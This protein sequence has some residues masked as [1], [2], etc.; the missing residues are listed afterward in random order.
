MEKNSKIFVAG[1][2]GLVGSAIVRKLQ[3]EGYTN[4]IARTRHELDLTNQE[5]V[6]IFFKRQK[7]EYV[8]LAAAKVG[9][10]SYNAKVPADFMYENLMIQTNVINSAY[11]NGC[12]KLLY[13]GSA[14]IYPKI[15]PQPIKEEYLLT[16]PLE[17]TNEGYALAK[18]A[19]LRMCQ[20]YKK[21]YGFNAISV[22]PA[23]LYG[24]NDNFN[25]ERGHVIP[26]MINKFLAAKENGDPSITCWGD[27]SPTREFLYVDDMADA[28][29]FLMHNYDG[30]EFL[31][32]GSD[33]EI[34]I[35]DLANIIK[36]SIG[37]TGK[38]VWDKS[39]PNGTPRRKM[40]N[41][42]LFDLGWKPSV[43]FDDGLKRTVEWYLQNKK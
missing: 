15:T 23:N 42:K 9:G 13:L 39:L 14:C 38:I 1:H 12:K 35:K 19:G 25:P 43:S 20:Y 5:A 36:K 3:A 28:C 4:I 17:P 16:A 10:I 11:L 21:Q 18:I 30:D 29:T 37:Y 33:T 24:I 7:P 8:F 2:K 32:V 26:G 40:D 27:G 22:M 41:T 6:S 34:K 31:N